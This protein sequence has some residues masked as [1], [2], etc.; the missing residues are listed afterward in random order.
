M[1]IQLYTYKDK[2]LIN[3][4]KNHEQNMDNYCQIKY[5]GKIT[6]DKNIVIT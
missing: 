2:D 3:I 1:Y 4:T 6:T 5:I